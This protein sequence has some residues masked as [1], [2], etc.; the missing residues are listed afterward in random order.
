MK[1]L[2]AN[3]NNNNRERER[4]R[5]VSKGESKSVRI[6]RSRNT[7]PAHSPAKKSESKQELNLVFEESNEAK[8][9]KETR[10]LSNQRISSTI[11]VEEHPK[12]ELYLPQK[13]VE[14]IMQHIKDPEKLREAFTKYKPKNKDLDLEALAAS[15]DT[16]VKCYKDC[17]YFGKLED[18]KISGKGIFKMR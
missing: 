18:N 17:A 3:N 14:E 10:H 1:I 2:R 15:P 12:E 8:E 11:L 7:S 9:K 16:T 4:D 13:D 6:R 5:S